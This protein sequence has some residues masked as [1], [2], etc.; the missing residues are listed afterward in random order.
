MS[1]FICVLVKKFQSGWKPTWKLRTYAIVIN[2][3]HNRKLMLHLPGTFLLRSTGTSTPWL[4]SM[5]TYRSPHP[6][7]SVLLIV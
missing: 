4:A 1:M 6:L 3:F 2:A 7:F 5:Y